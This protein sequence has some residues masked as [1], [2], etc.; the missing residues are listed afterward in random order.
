MSR[1]EAVVLGLLL[2]PMVAAVPFFV[3]WWGGFLVL[4]AE[5]VAYSALAGLGVGVLLDALF[6]RQFVRG[7]YAARPGALV[8]LYGFFSV[9]LFAVSMGVPVTHLLLGLIAGL[10]VGRALRHRRVGP[11]E[12]D[13]RIGRVVRLT[14]VAMVAVCLAS[15]T[16][17]LLSPS[18][19][20]DLQGIFGPSF[21]VEEPL[22]IG[23]IVSGTAALVLMQAWVTRRAARLAYG[24]GP[25]LPG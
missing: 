2:A 25:P 23:L 21:P 7:A 6:L 5:M 14:T 24:L 18:T 12:V 11:S 22:F 17:A 9:V 3:G 1:L 10:Y 4:P 8:G 20:R 13:A 19:P 15:A 16:I